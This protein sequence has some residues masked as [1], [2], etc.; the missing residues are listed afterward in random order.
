MNPAFWKNKKVLLTGHT[1]FKGSWLALWL[2]RSGAEVCGYA[3]EPPTS[4]SLFDIARVSE[5]VKSVVGDVRDLPHL[6]SIVHAE[7]PDIVIHMAA[8]ALVRRSYANPVETYSTNVMGTVNVLEAIRTSDCVRAA[9][10]VTTD[11]C[12]ENKEWIW[13]YRENDSLG[14]ADPYASSKSCSELVVTAYRNS[15]FARRPD[16]GNC[17][18][19]A[20]ARSGNVIGGGDWASDR[21]VPDTMNSLCGN[22]PVF[23]RYPQA[24]RPWQHV[25]DPLNGYLMLLERLWDDGAD[26]A[27]AWNFGP[28]PLDAKPVSWLVETLESL[29]GAETCWA[30]DT[31]DHVREAHWLALDSTKSRTLLNWVP[32]LKLATALEWV[33]E[34]YKAYRTGKAARILTEEQI[35]RFERFELD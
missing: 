11:K 18:A 30:S 1:G 35:A 32:K 16:D 25:L 2:Y 13:P 9:L 21:L 10:V 31:R 12:Y 29:W 14:G 6:R 26:L 8:Q 7:R 3:L 24:T 20:T 28:D 33:V 34:W 5:C 27:G 19:L 17:I 4:P 23:L 15:F 22:E